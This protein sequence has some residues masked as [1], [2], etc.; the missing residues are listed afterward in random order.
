MVPPKPEE[1][2]LGLLRLK[3]NRYDFY[4]KPLSYEESAS[5]PTTQ[6]LHHHGD[7]PAMAGYNLDELLHLSRSSVYG[8]IALWYELLSL[9]PLAHLPASRRSPTSSAAAK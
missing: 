4:G 2:S 3:K 8:Q 1:P 7:D 9:S 5:I 6:G